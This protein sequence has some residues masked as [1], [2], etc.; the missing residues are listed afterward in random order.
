MVSNNNSSVVDEIKDQG[1]LVVNL[2]VRSISVGILLVEPAN[3]FLNRE[4][5]GP[6]GHP[7]AE[8]KEESITE[9][10]VVLLNGVG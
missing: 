6:S 3:E 8:S 1:S 5:S 2:I 9:E 10:S 7:G 4:L